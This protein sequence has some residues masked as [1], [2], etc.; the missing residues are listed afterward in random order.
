MGGV[1]NQALRYGLGPDTAFE[2]GVGQTLVN[3]KLVKYPDRKSRCLRV[4]LQFAQLDGAGF[5]GHTFSKGRDKRL[6]KQHV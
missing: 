4:S 1:L 3:G 2:E 5:F 6:D